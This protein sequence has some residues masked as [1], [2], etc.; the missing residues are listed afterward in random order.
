[1]NTPNTQKAKPN[2]WAGKEVR[3]YHSKLGVFLPIMLRSRD[4]WAPRDPERDPERGNG[5]FETFLTENQHIFQNISYISSEFFAQ[6]IHQNHFYPVFCPKNSE[7]LVKNN[8]I[9]L[10]PIVNVPTECRLAFTYKSFFLK[11]GPEVLN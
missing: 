7:F 8:C 5:R 9:R 3:L 1:M 4:L 10:V 6:N 11:M 2:E